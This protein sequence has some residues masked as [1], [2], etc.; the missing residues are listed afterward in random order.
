MW[1]QVHAPLLVMRN[2]LQT[3]IWSSLV[4]RS[5]YSP[6]FPSDVVY[7]CVY[8]IY[9]GCK[10]RLTLVRMFRC[11]GLGGRVVFMA[12]HPVGGVVRMQPEDRFL[13]CLESVR[14][15]A[16]ARELHQR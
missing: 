3:G 4:E 12:Q 9:W 8:V 16:R 10:S 15:C 2:E 5:V 13:I 1:G 14:D 7:A 11:M 6:D